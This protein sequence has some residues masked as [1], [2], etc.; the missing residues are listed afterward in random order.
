M[1]GLEHALLNG[2]GMYTAA[3]TEGGG[4]MLRAKLLHLIHPCD[5]FF[6]IESRLPLCTLT[7]VLFVLRCR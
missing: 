6:Q 2:H 5:E 4:D 1:K 7:S 3:V